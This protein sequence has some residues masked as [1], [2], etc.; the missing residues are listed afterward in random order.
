MT[1]LNGFLAGLA[2]ISAALTIAPGSARAA[3]IC[4]DFLLTCENGQ[5]YPFCPR[6]VSQAGD[7]VTGTLATGPHHNG[8][9]MRLIPMGIGYRYAGK[10]I[11]FDGFQNAAEIYFSSSRSSLACTVSRQTLDPNA[12]AVLYTKG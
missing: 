7:V 10:G 9:R 5:S 1:K 2:V 8:I 3:G 6:A 12:P 4:A 11:W